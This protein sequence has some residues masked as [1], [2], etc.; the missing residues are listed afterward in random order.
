MSRWRSIW[1]PVVLRAIQP[2]RLGAAVAERLAPREPRT[3]LT[4]P[5]TAV[6]IRV[7][8]AGR[9]VLLIDVLSGPSVRLLLLLHEHAVVLD[10]LP[11]RAARAL[12]AHGA[13]RNLS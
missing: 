3:S 1:S 2:E 9:S 13:S 6:V 8:I 10:R 4:P 11:V 7:E 5:V 12:V